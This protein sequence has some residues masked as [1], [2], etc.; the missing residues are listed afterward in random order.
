MQRYSPGFH[1]RR[2]KQG[3]RRVSGKIVAV[4]RGLARSAAAGARPHR[5]IRVR[6][7]RT[8]VLGGLGRDLVL[9]IE[10][11]AQVDQ[12]AALAAE[13][14]GAIRLRRGGVFDRGFADRAAHSGLFRVNELKSRYQTQKS[15]PVT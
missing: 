1:R 8:R 13:W 14:I 12:L 4:D 9:A 10:P 2:M 3:K 6:F 5:S 7:G 11:A 15:R